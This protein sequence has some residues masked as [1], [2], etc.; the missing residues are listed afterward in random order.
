[1]PLAYTVECDGRS[2]AVPVLVMK[3]ESSTPF[4]IR[5]TLGELE[6]GLIIP[7]SFS[8]IKVEAAGDTT[9]EVVSLDAHSFFASMTDEEY[10]AVVEFIDSNTAAPAVTPLEIPTR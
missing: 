7:P 5:L 4:S 1:M 9:Q 6:N 10:S 3:A 8:H 2:A